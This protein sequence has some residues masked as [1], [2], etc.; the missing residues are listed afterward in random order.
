MKIDQMTKEE[1][2]KVVHY[3]MRCYRQA[4]M[5]IEYLE[6][7]NL[8]KEKMED[9]R[10]EKKTCLLI[11][12]TLMEMDRELRKIIEGEFLEK[13]AVKE[14]MEKHSRSNYY[15]LRNLA[16]DDFLRCL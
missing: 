13:R 8:V 1:K 3:L 6:E 4:K 11:Q 9:Y 15:R 16:V 14:M 7:C 5:N 12:Q 2:E 10:T